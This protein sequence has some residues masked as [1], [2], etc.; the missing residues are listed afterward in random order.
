MNDMFYG[1]SSLSN[2]DILNKFDTSLVTTMNSMF[3][4]CSSFKFRFIKL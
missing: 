3:K 1:C 2:L 4:E